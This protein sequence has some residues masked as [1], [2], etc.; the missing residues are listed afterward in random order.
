MNKL[1]CALWP[2]VRFDIDWGCLR[3][4]NRP[5]LDLG[6]IDPALVVEI[7]FGKQS[8]WSRV[9]VVSGSGGEE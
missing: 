6:E 3:L 9:F 5:R 8:R 7:D 1:L 2:S 4:H